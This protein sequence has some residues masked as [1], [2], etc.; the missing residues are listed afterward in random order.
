VLLNGK[1]PFEVWYNSIK[2]R[3]TR[4]RIEARLARVRAGNFGDFKSVGGEVFEFRLDFGPGYRIYFARIDNVVV[5][6]V[7]GGDKSAQQR[8]IKRAIELWK[9]H[10]DDA[11]RYQ[12]D[13]RS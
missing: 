13:F 7:V 9:E 12:R 11:E 6:L 10:K 5:V 2:D 4:L 1:C 3:S 8:D